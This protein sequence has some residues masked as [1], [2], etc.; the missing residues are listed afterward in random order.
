M[1]KFLRRVFIILVLLIIVFFIFRLIKPE[2]TTRFV[3]KVRS[4]PSTISGRFNRDRTSDIIIN[5]DTTK[6]TSNFEINNEKDVDIVYTNDTNYTNY[7]KGLKSNETSRLKRLNAEIDRILASWNNQSEWEDVNFENSLNLEEIISWLMNDSDLQISEITWINQDS[8]FVVIDVEQPYE[9]ESNNQVIIQN[10]N[11]NTWFVVIDVEQPYE[12]E[13]NN[14]TSTQT[15]VQNNTTSQKTNTTPAKQQWW[16]CGSW[17]TVQ[18]CEE[19]Y[20]VF[21]NININ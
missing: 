15:N 13:S 21:W 10:N 7:D 17:L 1:F 6:T 2:A 4:V 11:Q 8:W 16:D 14:Q 5:W 18:D 19:F 12:P 9:P 3:E 20:N